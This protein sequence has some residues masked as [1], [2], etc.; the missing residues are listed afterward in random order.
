MGSLRDLSLRLSYHKG[1]DDIAEDFYLPCMTRSSKYDRAVGYFRSSIFTLAWPALRE[2]VAAGGRIRIVCSPALAESDLAALNTAY[3][4]QCRD[5]FDQEATE[6]LDRLLGSPVFHRPTKILAGLVAAGVVDLKL[7]WIG[8]SASGASK[9]IFHDKVGIFT[10]ENSEQVVFK[11]S[12]NETWPGLAA[13]GNLESVDVFASWRN[14][15]NALRVEREVRYFSNLWSNRQPGVEVTRFPEIAYGRL[16]E[17]ARDSDWQH[18]LDELTIEMDR[19]AAV[20]ADCGPSPRLPRPHQIA[21]LQA[22]AD[23]GRQGILEHATGSGKTFTALCAVREALEEGRIP[24]V[25]VPSE[26]LLQQWKDEILTTFDDQGLALLVCGGGARSWS[27]QRRLSLW[28]SNDDRAEPRVVLATMQTASTDR[29]LSL[30][31]D[32]PHL[33]LIADEVHRLGSPQHQ[34]VLA[35]QSGWRLGLSATPVRAGDVDGTRL[36]FDYF[37]GVVPPPFTLQDAIQSGALTPYSYRSHRVA[38]NEDEQEE[39]E[40]LSTQ[41]AKRIATASEDGHLV[42]D[43]EARRLLIARARVAKKASAKTALAGDILSANY[44]H[45]QRWL[46]YCEDQVQLGDVK[47]ELVSRG[48][49]RVYDYHSAMDGDPSA[50]LALF[51]GSG[52][53][54]VAIRCLDEGV[55]IPAASHALILASSRNPREF[56]QR[57][58]RVLRTAPGKTIAHIHDAIVVPASINED[59]SPSPMVRGELARAI[60]FGQHAVNPDG[61]VALQAIAIDYGLDWE[62]LTGEGFEVDDAED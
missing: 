59:A 37:A 42:I 19:A 3:S 39:W 33:F 6:T 53:I 26:L 61:V 32:G 36:V 16:L 29:F 13:D 20:S 18:E 1:E 56:I 9:R 54:V 10:D 62:S 50:T 44:Q 21:A 46:V 14:E 17:I 22:W 47:T 49:P 15:E 60:E 8:D 24:L 41:I 30:L 27:E 43:D 55:D 51:E 31:R 38:L 11:G 25:L 52:G 57:R 58:G 45:G 5:S 12:M 4:D 2:F 48:L 34:K 7:A 28:T 35:V 40:G 23:A